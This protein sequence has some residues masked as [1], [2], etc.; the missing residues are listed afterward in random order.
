MIGGQAR[1]NLLRPVPKACEIGMRSRGLGF[2]G[3]IAT[4]EGRPF[5]EQ[6]E[7]LTEYEDGGGEKM[8]RDVARR[9]SFRLCS[10]GS[11]LRIAEGESVGSMVE[12]LFI[13]EVQRRFGFREFSRRK[14]F[15][16]V[17]EPSLSSGT[18]AR[19]PSRPE[20]LVSA[21]LYQQ[22]L[23]LHLQDLNSTLFRGSLLFTAAKKSMREAEREG[24]DGHFGFHLLSNSFT[25]LFYLKFSNAML[26]YLA[27]LR[28]VPRK[29]RIAVLP[30]QGRRIC[31]ISKW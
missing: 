9:V 6:D 8:L 11:D 12:R 25:Q 27:M 3:R 16:A 19:E 31:N 24:T 17:S 18:S 29:N 30:H 2:A 15:S 13:G 22:E 14:R 5:D 23:L 20:G 10:G 1:K 7:K 26:C 4:L 21:N 28:A